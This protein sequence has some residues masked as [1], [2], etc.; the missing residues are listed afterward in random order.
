MPIRRLIDPAPLRTRLERTLAGQVVLRLAELNPV[1]RGLAL[2][3]KLFTAVVPLAIILSS[4]MSSRDAVA[5]RV[6]EGFGLTG[7]GAAA[8]RD[9]LRVPAGQTGSA[10][11]V[12]GV[13]VLVYSMLSF[14]RALQRVYQDAWRLPAMRREGMAWGLLWVVAFAVWFSLSTPISRALHARGLNL[15]AVVVSV[16]LGSILWMITPFIL[17]GRRI[18]MRALLPGGVATAVLLVAFNLGSRVYLPRSTTTN[19]GRYGLVGVT[20]TILTW[21]F[22]F[23]LTLIASAAIGAVLNERRSGNAQTAGEDPPRSAHVS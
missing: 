15:G 4:V 19:V 10:I 7:A 14:S 17:L 20:F 2:G 13:L 6:I 1:E 9:L 16:A 23:S 22:A 3:S 12:I 5:T 21:L 18:A 11:S 8:L